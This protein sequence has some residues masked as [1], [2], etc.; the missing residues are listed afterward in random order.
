MHPIADFW[1]GTHTLS[2][3]WGDDFGTKIL[4]RLPRVTTLKIN[5]LLVNFMNNFILEHLARCVD[6]FVKILRENGLLEKE[7]KER[8]S[9]Y[10]ILATCNTGCERSFR[11]SEPLWPE[12]SIFCFALLSPVTADNA[13]N[14]GPIPRW[15]RYAKVETKLAYHWA[16]KFKRI[17]ELLK[18]SRFLSFGS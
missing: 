7:E 5:S 9:R 17:N 13:L 3:V 2:S 16:P 18:R 11:R 6:V 4:F 10:L 1:S 12:V 14:S 15:D 8:N